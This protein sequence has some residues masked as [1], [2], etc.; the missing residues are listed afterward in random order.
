MPTTL[1]TMR[2]ALEQAEQWT[3]IPTMNKKPRMIDITIQYYMTQQ[4]LNLI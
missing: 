1:L 4:L 2:L 3:T